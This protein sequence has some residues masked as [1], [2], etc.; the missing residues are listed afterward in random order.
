MHAFAASRLM[1]NNST[2]RFHSV[3]MFNIWHKILLTCGALNILP[4]PFLI[5]NVRAHPFPSRWSRR[6]K[7]GKRALQLNRLARNECPPL[8]KLKDFRVRRPA[9]LRSRFFFE[10]LPIIVVIIMKSSVKN[11]K[12]TDKPHTKLDVLRGI[13]NAGTQS[14]TNIF[15]GVL[16]GPIGRVR[17]VWR[18]RTAHSCSTWQGFSICACH[19]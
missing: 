5:L 18:R 4:S 13:R 2:S 6:E 12:P 7:E 15:R 10:N 14:P 8:R 16:K 1:K 9:E 17:N 19:P 11:T 3:F